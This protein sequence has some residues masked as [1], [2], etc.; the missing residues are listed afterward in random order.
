MSLVF[1]IL[2]VVLCGIMAHVI[3]EALPRRWFCA[4]RWPYAPWKWERGGAIYD[5]IG[6]RAWKD[7]LPDMSR[8]VRKMV[9]KRFDA[10]PTA[11]HA[12]K[13]IAETC[14]AEATHA[15]LCFVAPVIWLFWRNYVG[16]ILTAIVIICN[17]PFILI[18]RYNRPSLVALYGRLTA[19]EER[20]RNASTDSVRKYRR[21]T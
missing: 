9:P 3:G 12:R 16:V 11:E 2:Y 21:G 5:K 15:V 4:E 13:L 6:I 10:F 7:R 17:L 1:T 14:V 20:R 19:R 8:V 18:Q